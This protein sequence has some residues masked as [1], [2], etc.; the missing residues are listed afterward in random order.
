M[1]DQNT[2]KPIIVGVILLLVVLG[3]FWYR[4][5]SSTYLNQ[6]QISTTTSDTS[7][8]TSDGSNLNPIQTYGQVKLR[9]NESSKF[10]NLTLTPTKVIEDSRCPKGVNCIWAGTVKVSLIINSAVGRSTPTIELGKSVTTE[11]EKITLVSVEPM[12]T[13]VQIAAGDYLLTFKVEKLATTPISA[14]QGC[15]IGGCSAQICSD[16]PNAVSTCIYKA[17][18]ACYK[19]ATCERQAT[20]QCGWTETP[21]LKMCISKAPP[22]PYTQTAQ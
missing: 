9:L 7:T 13:T 21:A 2:S 5:N 15:Y 10:T 14:G 19:T 8:T 4:S 6:N 20:G 1:S 12:K 3:Y 11:S 22:V 18:Y 16:D 17:E